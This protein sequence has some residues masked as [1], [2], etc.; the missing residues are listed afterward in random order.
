MV[1]GFAE[2]KLRVQAV[3]KHPCV[4]QLVFVRTFQLTRDSK[5]ERS[6]CV[7]TSVIW[8]LE[9]WQTCGVLGTGQRKPPTTRHLALLCC[10]PDF[11]KTG[12]R[13]DDV[14]TILQ[15]PLL[16]SWRWKP[17]TMCRC[18]NSHHRDM[19]VTVALTWRHS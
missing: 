16:G 7:A 13:L 18:S 2:T 19:S 10:L 3:C 9:R 14:T 15:W 11:R 5:Y 8:E 1:R 4:F 6:C 12:P 17:V